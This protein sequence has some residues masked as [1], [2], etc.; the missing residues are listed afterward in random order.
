MFWD[1][2]HVLSSSRDDGRRLTRSQGVLA[3]RSEQCRQLYDIVGGLERRLADQQ[4]W[5]LHTNLT[6][7][8]N[9]MVLES[10][11]HHKTVNL[12]F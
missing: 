7:R 9:S 3:K 4:V 6:Q 11:L 12:L 10:Q 8:I 5:A 1:L 2:T